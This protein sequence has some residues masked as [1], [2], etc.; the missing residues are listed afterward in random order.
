MA[1]YAS[2]VT[3]DIARWHSSGLIDEA[4]AQAL[5]RDVVQNARQGFSF[6]TVLTIL[7]AVLL[8]AALLLLVAAN[9]EAFPRLARVAMIFGIILAGYVGGAVASRRGST[10]LSELL[11]I[12]AATAFGG[13]IALVAQMY[14]LS[15]EETDAILI[16]CLGTLAAAAAL[17]SPALTIGAVVLGSTWLIMATEGLGWRAGRD[18]PMSYLLLAAVMWGVSLWTRSASARH[19]ILLS[20]MGFA[21]IHHVDTDTLVAPIGLTIVSI[22]LFAWC[23]LQPAESERW[24]KLNEGGTVQGLLGFIVGMSAIQF[25]LYEEPEFIYV[26]IVVFAGVIGALLL[27]GRDNRL[28]RVLA[29]TAFV[30][31][32]CFV[33]VV[34]VGSMLGTA[35]FFLIAGLVLALLAWLIRRVERRF[36]ASAGAKA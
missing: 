2:A 7:A 24:L 5:T 20:L 28:L 19:L 21:I 26:A 22:A 25:A 34:L 29:Y 3:K 4:T 35:G 8:A 33:Y 32:I 6:G 31:E 14:H 36:T 30:Y 10:A 16:W 13:G 18:I 11:F 12:L 9:W 27:G 17:R 15:G 1:G 23:L